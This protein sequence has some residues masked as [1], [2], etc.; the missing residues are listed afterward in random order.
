[1]YLVFS[2]TSKAALTISYPIVSFK[3]FLRLA[4]RYLKKE[5]SM[6]LDQLKRSRWR[7]FVFAFMIYLS[8]SKD[9]LVLHYWEDV[10]RP[11]VLSVIR[12]YKLEYT[13]RPIR[14]YLRVDYIMLGSQPVVLLKIALDMWLRSGVLQ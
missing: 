4:T 3:G 9:S 6:V 13:L 8:L 14:C 11:F 5:K 1:M 7:L 2:S 10:M 12:V